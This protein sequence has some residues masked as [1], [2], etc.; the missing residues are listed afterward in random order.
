MPGLFHERKP[1]PNLNVEPPRP[2]RI[3]IHGAAGK[4][5][6]YMPHPVCRTLK[7]ASAPQC[8]QPP[9][10]SLPPGRRCRWIGFDV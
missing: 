1:G 5:L 8:F 2:R 10:M 9:E 4:I 3:V 7:N 6:R